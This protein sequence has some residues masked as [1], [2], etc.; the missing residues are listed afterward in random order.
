MNI[1]LY[2]TVCQ[3]NVQRNEF[4][5]HSKGSL[6]LLCQVWI[7]AQI[8]HTCN[9]FTVYTLKTYNLFYWFVFF[10]GGLKIKCISNIGLSNCKQAIFVGILWKQWWRFSLQDI[11][12]CQDSLLVFWCFLCKCT[13]YCIKYQ[14]LAL[15]FIYVCQEE[16]NSMC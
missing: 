14:V 15:L 12:I 16:I 4:A 7:Y 11:Y 3:R 10:A 8:I 13:K 5:T 1:C 6:V 2:R 9:Y